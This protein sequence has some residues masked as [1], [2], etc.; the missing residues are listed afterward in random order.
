MPLRVWGAVTYALLPPMLGAVATGRLRPRSWPSLLPLPLL[1]PSRASGCATRPA[2]PR[3][4]WGGRRLLLAVIAAFVPLVYLLAL[5]LLAVAVVRSRGTPRRRPAAVAVAVAGAAAAAAAVAAGPGART[6]TAARWRPGC[7]A[8]ASRPDL[9][10]L[11]V[12]LLHPGGPG[13]PPL[14]LAAGLLLAA[15]A[16]L[17]RPDR[18]RLVLLPAGS[19]SGRPRRRRWG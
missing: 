16:A 17:L 3:P 4:A 2:A 11:D 10:G 7:P 12:L 14:L 9:D 6:R 5:V 13:L 8:R 18:R 19:P 1:A 15:L